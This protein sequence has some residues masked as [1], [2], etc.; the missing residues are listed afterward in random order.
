VRHVCKRVWTLRVKTV[1]ILCGSVQRGKMAAP[2]GKSKEQSPHGTGR[3]RDEDEQVGSNTISRPEG[4]GEELV[5]RGLCRG[6]LAR[7]VTLGQ[8]M[9]NP[10]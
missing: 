5:E 6:S 4:A 9:K 3:C 2:T 10:L 7:A 1:H 8:E